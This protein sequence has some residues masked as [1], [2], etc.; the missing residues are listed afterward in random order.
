MRRLAPLAAVVVLAACGG[1]SRPVPPGAV[2]LVG[3]RAVTRAALGLELAHV[4]RVY[5][6]EQK[7][8]PARGTGAYREIQDN[9]VRLLVD[10]ARLEVEAAR[11][12][13]SVTDAQVEARLMRIKQSAF[14]GDEERYRAQLIRTGTTD[15]AVHEAIRIALLSDALVGKHPKAPRVEYAA[16]FEPAGTS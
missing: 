4:R 13:V 14:G 15:A 2:A 11:E 5:A 1:E 16:G 12:G 9:V 8:F 6:L 10:R 3:D 7:T